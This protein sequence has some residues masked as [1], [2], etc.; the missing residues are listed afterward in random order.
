[1]PPPLV[2]FDLDGVLCRFTDG[3]CV[4]HGRPVAQPAVWAF[5]REWG[6]TDA[7]FYAPQGREF[8]AGLG[9]WEDG[10]AL[11]AAAEALVG[12]SRILFVTS[13][14]RTD[15]CTDGKRDWFAAHLPAYDPWA[16]LMVGGA[17]FKLAHLA[18]VLVDDSD[19]NCR[20]FAEAGGRT[21]TPPRT[22]NES[23]HLADP[24]SS[25]F[26]AAAQAKILE[27]EVGWAARA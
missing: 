14:V 18:A 4:A 7:E 15:G 17:K 8:W 11:L 9:R 23:R 25:L 6:I 5:H 3:A 13:P 16:D 2:M 22:W 20:A 21:L 26:D 19:A 12:R 27:Q 10:F 1:M 24:E